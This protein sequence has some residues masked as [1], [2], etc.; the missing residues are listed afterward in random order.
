MTYYAVVDT[1]VL[2]SAL[3]TNNKTAAT[4]QILDRLMSGE[5]TTVYSKEIMN[6]YREVFSRSK[7]RI[8]P[9]SINYVLS[10]IEKI[11]IMVEPS[12]TGAML[13]DMNDLPFYEVVMEKRDDDAYLVTGNMKHFPKEPFIVTP[14]EMLDILDGKK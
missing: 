1:N 9:D 13:P 10:T 7:F 6:E 5:F 2:V 11:G 14:R 12:P 4:S 8:D 3:I